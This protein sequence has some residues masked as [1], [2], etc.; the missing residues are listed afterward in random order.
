MK[1]K[2]FLLLIPILG[3]SMF[4]RAQGD[5]LITPTRV[6]F[7]GNKQKT[8]LNLVNIGK[9]T[10]TYSVSF[11]QYNM[12]E[13]GTFVSIEKPDAGQMFADP[14][15]R[16]FPRTI[17]LAP[18]EPQVVMLQ[19]KR[20]SDM[21]TG[22][23]RSHLYFRADK[24]A[25]PLGL[26][27]T[28]KD[29]TNLKVELIPIFGLSIPIIIRSGIVNVSS[30]LSDMKLETQADTIHNL[31][32]TIN[33]TGNISLYGDII[34]QFIPPTGKAFE[35]GRVNGLGVYTN[36][37]KRN[38]SVRLHNVPGSVLKNGKLK[39]QYV[40]NDPTQK[41]VTVYAESELEVK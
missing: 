6:V 40:S 21:A 31:K 3:L 19:C 33:R 26:G 24:K 10:A 8:E 16:I 1:R 34:V 20:K 27:K 13:E 22:E 17:T 18:G 37:N 2:L 36:I 25:N 35:I 11:L 15:L 23:Y 7:E 38:V 32:L 14:Y 39:V 41:T 30:T 4:S 29:T 5:L 28:D 12:T 9:D